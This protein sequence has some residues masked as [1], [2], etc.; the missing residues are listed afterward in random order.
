MF[1]SISEADEEG[2]LMP[3]KYFE[4]FLKYKRWISTPA[5]QVISVLVIKA[6]G[7][8][9]TFQLSFFFFFCPSVSHTILDSGMLT[10]AILRVSCFTDWARQEPLENSNFNSK[11][12]LENL[13][14]IGLIFGENF[15]CRSNLGSF[16]Q[17]INDSFVLPAS[18]KKLVIFEKFVFNLSHLN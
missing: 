13:G 9:I 18:W 8:H 5:T 17:P 4:R 14:A 15:F 1:W 16:P 12:L 11:A 3:I 10:I 7:K 2:E 6:Y